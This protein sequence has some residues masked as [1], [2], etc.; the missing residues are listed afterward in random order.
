[1]VLGNILTLG[2]KTTLLSSL[3]TIRYEDPID[4][5]HDIDKSG[6]PLIFWK[7]ATLLEYMK[8]HPG[9]IQARLYQRRLLFSA[10]SGGIPQ[11]VY[12]MYVKI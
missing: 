3:V 5:I 12:E 11:W 10:N 2:Y 6:L 9:K 7:G 1:M 4:N 8:T